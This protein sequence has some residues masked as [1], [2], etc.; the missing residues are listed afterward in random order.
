[1]SKGFAASP[2]QRLK[3]RDADCIV[4]GQPGCDPAHVIDR[5]LGGG[6]HQNDVVPLCRGCHRAYDTGALDLLP[7]LNGHRT[8]QA[9]AVRL[10]GLEAAYR[11]ITN[12]RH[13]GGTQDEAFDRHS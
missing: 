3:C 11:R 4:C 7:H 8:E 9:H 13:P 5:A 12:S 6:D 10:V 2:A 1:M